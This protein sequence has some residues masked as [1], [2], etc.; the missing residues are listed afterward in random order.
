[1]KKIYILLS[2]ALILAAA[3]TK[4]NPGTVLRFRVSAPESEDTKAT[5]E[6]DGKG[7]KFTWETDDVLCLNF[8][9]GG[10]YYQADASIDAGSIS[11]GS[12]EFTVTLPSEIDGTNPF[13]VYAIYQKAQHWSS[14]QNRYWSGGPIFQFVTTE[15]RGVTLDKKASSTAPSTMDDGLM[16]PALYGEQTGVTASTLGSFSLAHMGWVLCV[17]FQN[18]SGSVMDAP[19]SVAFTDPAFSYFAGTSYYNVETGTFNGTGG[20]VISLRINEDSTSYWSEHPIANGEEVIFYRWLYSKTDIPALTPSLQ[21]TSSSPS[22]S[23]TTSLS[24]KTVSPGKM[25]H[26]YLY[27]DGTDLTL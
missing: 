3:C 21:L 8:E 5:I 23:A 16:R 6:R 12:A 4:E 10:N 18:N 27:W 7:L 24:A 20:G 19:Y 13:N 9:Q 2:A 1:M 15:Y 14:S 22:V 11:G 17:H 26:V 25:Y